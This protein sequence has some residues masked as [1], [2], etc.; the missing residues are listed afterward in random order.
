MP[1]LCSPRAPY[2]ALGLKPIVPVVTVCS[3]TPLVKFVG[4]LLNP[5]RN[6]DQDGRLD[7]LRFEC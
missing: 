5:H 4:V 7:R 6:R 3:P 2:L 1:L